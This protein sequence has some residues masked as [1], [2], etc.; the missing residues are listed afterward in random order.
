MPV[1]CLHHKPFAAVAACYVATFCHFSTLDCATIVGVINKNISYDSQNK[2]I[3]DVSMVFP[4]SFVLLS[5]S[6]SCF[7]F[8]FIVYCS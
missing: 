8:I 4:P 7:L 1:A 2:R 3:I 5:T 6:P